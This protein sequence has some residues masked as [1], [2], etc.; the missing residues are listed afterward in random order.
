MSI[1][2]IIP[3]YKAPR[4]LK[5]TVASIVNLKSVDFN[6]YLSVD[7]EEEGII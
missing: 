1:A 4:Q 5:N 3:T 2:V 7:G 6:I